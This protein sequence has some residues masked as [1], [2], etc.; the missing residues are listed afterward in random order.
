MF[1]HDNNNK[2]ME[3]WSL[4]KASA[5]LHLDFTAASEAQLVV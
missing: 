5:I 1:F 2:S 4:L 3:V